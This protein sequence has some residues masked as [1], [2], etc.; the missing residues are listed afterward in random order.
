MSCL[1]IMRS[2]CEPV[3]NGGL[4]SFHCTFDLV[5]FGYLPIMYSA[6]WLAAGSF[7]LPPYRWYIYAVDVGTIL[8][9][10]MSPSP[11]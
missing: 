6:R 9:I 5:S 7:F 10:T 2:G 4:V 11:R 8:L 3:L 1:L